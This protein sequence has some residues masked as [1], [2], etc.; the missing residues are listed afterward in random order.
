MKEVVSERERP[1]QE[2]ASLAE[3]GD[4]MRSLHAGT[5]PVASGD[6]VT[7]LVEG[8]DP[9][10][11]AAAFG[12]DPAS[13][14]VRESMRRTVVFCTGD[15]SVEEAEAIMSEHH[16]DH[17]P[18]VDSSLRIIGMLSRQ[19]LAERAAPRRRRTKKR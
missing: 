19:M 5:F 14:L 9:D 3:A 4:T 12:H 7:G 13:T 15:Q 6:R 17:L 11:R 10:R 18:V 16:L 1:V 8:R 2:K